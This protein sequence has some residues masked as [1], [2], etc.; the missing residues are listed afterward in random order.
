VGSV[1]ERSGSG[2]RWPGA[3]QTCGFCG[4]AQPEVGK[5]IAGSAGY[6]CDACVRLA[7][8][9]ISAGSPADAALGP[10]RAVPEQDGGTRCS[11]CGKA[12]FRVAG[13]AE[14]QGRTT[15]CVECLLLCNEII[16]DELS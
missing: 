4:R 10:V 13:L 5:L 6:I 7:E 12:R 14:S 11:F 2:G 8:G 9:V 16:D 15:I 1:D 3:H